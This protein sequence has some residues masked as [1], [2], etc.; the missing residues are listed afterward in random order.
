MKNAQLFPVVCFIHDDIP[1]ISNMLVPRIP[2]F[3][4]NDIPPASNPHDQPLCPPHGQ[5]LAHF[6]SEVT[7]IC[8]LGLKHSVEE[9][10]NQGKSTLAC[11]VRAQKWHI[12]SEQIIPKC[13]I[14]VITIVTSL[15]R[16]G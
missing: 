15:C 3:I 14:N 6:R 5:W 16:N 4:H 8:H 12:N 7:P 1:H 9:G 11:S 2:R 13:S 10:G